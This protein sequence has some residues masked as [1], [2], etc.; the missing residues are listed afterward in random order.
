MDPRPAS[1]SKRSNVVHLQLE[2][3]EVAQR[4]HDQRRTSTNMNQTKRNRTMERSRRWAS[5][6]LAIALGL[7]VLTQRSAVEVHATIQDDVL[8]PQQIQAVGAIVLDERTAAD[9]EAI[10]KENNEKY[11]GGAPLKTDPELEE[12]LRRAKMFADEAS[13]RNAT[14]LWQKVLS[15]SGDSL[16]TRDGETYFSL[17]T[18]VEDMISQLPPD[19]LRQYRVTADGEARAAIAG[20]VNQEEGMQIVVRQ[21][22]LSSFGD[23]AAYFLGC[24]ALDRYDFLNAQRMFRKI[25]EHYPDPSVSMADVWLRL[26]VA[27]AHVGDKKTAH[28]AFEMA[29]TV[30]RGVD[31]DIMTLVNA[32]IETAPNQLL[33]DSG[34]TQSDWKMDMGGPSRKGVMAGLPASV[35]ASDLASIWAYEFPVDMRTAASS[36]PFGTS[37]A[38]SFVAPQ[39][40]ATQQPSNTAADKLIDSWRKNMW[41]P[42]T[43]MLVV[44]DRIIFK[45]NNDLVSW[46]IGTQASEP[47]WRSLWLNAFQQDEASAK[48]QQMYNAYGM[49]NSGAKPTQPNEV[50][51]FGDTIHYSMCVVGDMVISLEGKRFSRYGGSPSISQPQQQGYTFG[52][53]PRRART[54]YMTAYDLESGKLLWHTKAEAVMFDEYGTDDEV[55]IDEAGLGFMAAPIPFGRLL[56]VPVSDGG[57]IWLYALDSDNQGEVVWSSYL[58]DEPVGGSAN[59]SPIGM[60]LEG[61]DLY[62]VCGTGVVFSVDAASGAV[63]YARRYERDGRENETMRQYGRGSGM[64]DLEGWSQDM[65]IPFGN[66][67]VVM[68]SDHNDVFALDRQTGDFKWR[69]P[70]SPFDDQATYCMGFYDNKIYCGGPKTVL[71]YDLAGEGRL[72]WAR[73]IEGNSYGRGMVTEDGVYIPVD[74]SILKLDLQS[75]QPVKQ[76]GVKLPSRAP[77][78]NLYSDGKRIWTMAM[79]QVYALGNLEQQIDIL[80]QAIH[81]GDLKALR[82]RAGLF[83]KSNRIEDGMADLDQLYRKVRAGGEA[84]AASSDLIDAF[85][86]VEVLERAPRA[87]LEQLVTY[88]TDVESL[89]DLALDANVLKQRSYLLASAIDLLRAEP[90]DADLAL[91]LSLVERIDVD[92]LRP[93]IAVVLENNLERLPVEKVVAMADSQSQNVAVFALPMLARLKD[94]RVSEIAKRL[95]QVDEEIVRLVAARSLFEVGDREGLSTLVNLLDSSD[96]QMRAM[97]AQSLRDVTG[98]NISFDPLGTDELRVTH[99]ADWTEWTT[100]NGDS[101][102]IKAPLP[103]LNPV[104]GRVLIAANSNGYVF[105]LNSDREEVWRK[106]YTD[107]QAIQG[108]PNGNIL[109]ASYGRRMVI[110]ID[111]DGEEVWRKTQLP[112]T[113]SSVQRLENGNTLVT[114]SQPSGEILEIDPNGDT[115]WRA[116]PGA[117]PICARRLPNGNTLVSLMSNG[118]VVE[119]D[120]DG[121]VVWE[122]KNQ[123][124]AHGVRR[125]ENGNTLV[126]QAYQGKIVEYDKEKNAVWSK[127]GLGQVF[128]MERLPNGNTMIATSQGVVEVDKQGNQVWKEPSSVMVKSIDSY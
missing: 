90:T 99:V 71:C 125:L 115:V 57:A 68:A 123:H 41:Q 65:I 110:E 53:V 54:N 17:S 106:Q 10:R 51:F 118:R 116:T 126:A 61:R 2:S 43:R 119:I 107:I 55:T 95:L 102:E 79:N 28:E 128:D 27:A 88:T 122:L 64:L 96:V 38:D 37:L 7:F 26:S 105:E 46:D 31:A 48:M 3:S 94:G 86:S 4:L 22:F 77:V 124:S 117:A 67:L 44:G 112:G 103:P 18:E 15:D 50:M 9:F 21:F 100:A 114:C 35:M 60:A 63:R 16:I 83:I 33:L 109:L 56:L 70:R 104:F 121:E 36:N 113:P 92:S 76:V 108:L 80:T 40:T 52:T 85:E 34:S 66:S 5:L 20:A 91:M 59:W 72:A 97:S 78:G 25:I 75:G 45:T 47:A 89:P 87:A 42:Q 101:F 82:Q 14:L 62:L 23:D 11:S 49:A 24:L 84:T 12:L 1:K 73:R 111:R 120:R 29:K 30:G 98:E 13:Y 93:Q 32:D 39:E 8:A 58:C 19:G 6:S 74:D 127:D 69:A 81:Q